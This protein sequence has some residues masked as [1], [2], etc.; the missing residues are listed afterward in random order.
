MASSIGNVTD[1]RLTYDPA[2]D[3]ILAPVRL[4]IEPERIV[5]VGHQVFK[6]TE[7]MVQTLV[8]KGFRAS[9]QSGNLL[10][11]EMLVSLDVVPDAPAATVTMQDGAFVF[12]TVDSGGLSGLQASASDLLRNVNAIPFAAIGHNLEAM[13]KNMNDAHQQSATADGADSVDGDIERCAI[14]RQELG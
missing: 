6:N 4:E 13:T 10:T 14:A 11:G 5:G 8:N 9:L 12:P 7:D 3:A 2:K 1:V